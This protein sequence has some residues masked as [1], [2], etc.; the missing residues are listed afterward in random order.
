MVAA[1]SRVL[2]GTLHAKNA[3]AEAGENLGMHDRRARVLA[4]IAA[5]PGDAFAAHDVVGVDHV[6]DAGNGGHMSAD[7]DRRVGESW[8]TRRHISRTLPKLGM[9][10]EMPTMS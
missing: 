6:V 4:E 3:Q 5:H 8:R 10:P 7:D 2:S 9:M 1:V